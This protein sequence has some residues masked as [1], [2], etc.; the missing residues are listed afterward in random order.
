MIGS[1]VEFRVQRLNTPH[2]SSRGNFMVTKK[3]VVKALPRKTPIKKA[4]KKRPV[5]ERPQVKLTPKQ[6]LFVKEYLVDLNATQASIRAG[7]SKKSAAEIGYENLTKPQ[8]MQAIFEGMNDREEKVETSAEWVLKALHGEAI[9]DISD[10]YSIGGGLKPVHEWPLVWRTGLVTGV[11]VKQGFEYKDG[12][13]FPV[14]VVTE[15]KLSDRI[16]RLEL[17]GKHHAMFTDNVNLGGEISL[18]DKTDAEIDAQIL[19]LQKKVG[20]L[21][22]SENPRA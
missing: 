21:Q 15:I 13:K 22:I 9:A 8:I 20:S 7:Y 4:V 1:V 19:M 12:E 5:A 18:K 17:I 10:L 6:R 11:K 2:L 16:K 14:G 3:K